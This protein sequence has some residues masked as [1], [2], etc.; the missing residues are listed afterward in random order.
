AATQVVHGDVEIDFPTGSFNANDHG[1]S[2][3]AA[4]EALIMDVNCGRENLEA[5]ALVIEQGDRI[6]DYHVG[7]LADGF[8]SDLFAGFDRRARENAG[9]LNG[10]FG[11]EV[12][13]YAALDFALDENQGRDP[14][15]AVGIF[16]HR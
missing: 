2:V 4:A 7:E 6:S 15:P 9:N 16:L 5:K 14:F 3:L 8:A 12:E 10:H 11:S 13:D 1:F